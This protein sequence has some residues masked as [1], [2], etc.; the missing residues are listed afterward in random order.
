MTAAIAN[1]EK[2]LN[3]IDKKHRRLVEKGGKPKM[4]ETGLVSMQPRSDFRLSLRPL[5][6]VLFGFLLFKGFLLASLGPAGYAERVGVLQD[7]TVVEQVGAVIMQVDIVTERI[8][9][10]FKIVL[11]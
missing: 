10:A 2:R 7:G 6:Y 5:V 11:K 4:D 9:D 1:F 3:K 8:A